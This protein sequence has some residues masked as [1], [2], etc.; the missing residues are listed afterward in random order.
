M[1]YCWHGQ[2]PAGHMLPGQMSPWQLASFKYGPLKCGTNRI[3]NSWD[4]PHME[5]CY[6]DNNMSIACLEVADKFVV[7]WGRVVVVVV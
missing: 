1:R 6:L 5:K 4:I 7:G 2:M 3:S